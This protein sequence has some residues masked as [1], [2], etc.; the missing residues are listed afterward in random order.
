MFLLWY[1][2]REHL[3]DL[4]L[5]GCRFSFTFKVIFIKA[6]HFPLLSQSC[7]VLQVLHLQPLSCNTIANTGN[8]RPCLVRNIILPS[9]PCTGRV[10]QMSHYWKC[11]A[12]QVLHY[13]QFGSSFSSQDNKLATTL[14]QIVL[15]FNLNSCISIRQKCRF[16]RILLLSL[17]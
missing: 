1:V 15:Q 17:F 8:D 11:S 10:L 12:S 6:L 2:P 9:P 7:R 16:P 4:H 13:V 5:D 14:Q 3:I